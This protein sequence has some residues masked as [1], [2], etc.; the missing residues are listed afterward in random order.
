MYKSITVNVS[1]FLYRAA[2]ETYTALLKTLLFWQRVAC[3][4]KINNNTLFL[5]AAAGCLIIIYI[6]IPL[7]TTGVSA[8][9][10]YMFYLRFK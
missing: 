1:S 3:R 5:R 10:R 9:R 8:S 4:R 6:Y 7:I 2:L